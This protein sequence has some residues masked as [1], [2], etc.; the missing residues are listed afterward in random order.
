LWDQ[1]PASQPRNL[2]AIQ[3]HFL[4][5]VILLGS[6]SRGKYKTKPQKNTQTMIL[7]SITLSTTESIYYTT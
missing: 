2:L 6:P 3:R 5:W 4:S 7:M 1:A